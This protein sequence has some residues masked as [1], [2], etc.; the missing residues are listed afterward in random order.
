[1]EQE[2]QNFSASGEEITLSQEDIAKLITR[3]K[4]ILKQIE[5]LNAEYFQINDKLDS[6]DTQFD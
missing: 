3:R 5:I 4:D 2:K 1:M 6:V